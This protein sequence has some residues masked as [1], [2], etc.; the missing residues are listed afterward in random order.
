MAATK[1]PAKFLC[2]SIYTLHAIVKL[3]AVF[4]QCRGYRMF[5]FKRIWIF[6]DR[7]CKDQS[8]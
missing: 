8:I 2:G 5:G 6:P 7:W 4:Q 1:N 3:T